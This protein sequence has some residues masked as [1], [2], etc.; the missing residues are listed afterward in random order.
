LNQ[1]AVTI[2]EISGAPDRRATI[3]TPA[4]IAS[5]NTFEIPRYA[6]TARKRRDRRPDAHHL[7]SQK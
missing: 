2:R 4:S 5:S 7:M 3:G 1:N 6:M